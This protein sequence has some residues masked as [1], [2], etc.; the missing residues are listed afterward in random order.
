VLRHT[1]GR[2]EVFRLVWNNAE[3]ST[4]AWDRTEVFRLACNDAQV[5]KRTWINAGSTDLPATTWRCLCP[6][7]TTRGVFRLAWKDADLFLTTRRCS[8][9]PAPRELQTALATPT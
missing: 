1:F 6:P 8:D 9:C 5:S 3:V 7:L 2:R 4:L